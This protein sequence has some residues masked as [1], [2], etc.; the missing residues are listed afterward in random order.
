MLHPLTKL[1]SNVVTAIDN[2][3][4]AFT[5]PS[6]S[7][8]RQKLEEAFPGDPQTQEQVREKIAANLDEAFAGA[9]L[10]Q[11]DQTWFT[12]RNP[13]AGLAQS[14]MNV[15]ALKGAAPS[16]A[17]A[18][19]GGAGAAPALAPL[20]QF[21]PLD[22]EWIEC[23]IDGFKTQLKGKAPFVQHQNLSDFLQTI[24]DRVVI[25]LV[26][27][28]G[29]H[30]DAAMKVA[31]QIRDA[32]PDI[33]IH[34]GDIYYAGQ[35]NEATEAL[36]IW[37]L[38]DPVTKAIPPGTSFALNGNHEMFCGGDAYFGEVFQAFGQKASYFGLRNN[39]WQIL[40]F[41][42]A[43]V[44]FRLLSPEDAQKPDA[45]ARLASQWNWLVDKFKNSSLPTIL[46]SHHEPISSSAQEFSD[47][48]NLRSD[49]QK[50]L[51][52]AGRPPFGWFFG[53][54]HLC[55]IYDFKPDLF[56]A[57]GRLIGHGA[58][59]HS[60]PAPG[61]QADPGCFPAF[62]M[63]TQANSDGNAMSGFALLKFDG[64]KIDISYI[65]EDG[66]VFHA[67]TWVANQAS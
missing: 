32:K 30:N 25:A 19:A 54:E 41:D 66:S 62:L 55:T 12:P 38:A 18:G 26:G 35:H 33:V 61:E 50:F 13:M 16:A 22:P 48:E 9:S 21:G 47:G 63:N 49:C 57:R 42:S 34:L 46:L 59:P 64:E 15:R 65:N 24:D 6:N 8:V 28:W 2:A 39:F 53:H 58:I 11:R 1:Q 40:A 67:E 37:P 44:E 36:N 5:D 56:P 43:Y 14:A 60:P 20:E 29:A 17:D 4:N 7:V 23:V 51:A 10:E 52:A 27:D 3:R 31:Q 45:D